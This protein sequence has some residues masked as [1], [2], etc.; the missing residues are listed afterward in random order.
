MSTGPLLDFRIMDRMPGDIVEEG[1][2]NWTLRLASAVPVARVEI[3]V[4]GEVVHNEE[5][6][7]SPGEQLYAGKLNLPAGGWVAARA[8]GSYEPDSEWPTMNGYPFAHSSPIWIGSHAS[9]DLSAARKA[10]VELLDA[11]AVA[12]QRLLIGYGGQ[13]IPKLKAR[14]AETRLKLEGIASR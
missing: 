8:H 13:S 10:A 11:L 7:L 12:E 2:S 4:N 6:L 14:F 1:L 3:L 9:T 5:G